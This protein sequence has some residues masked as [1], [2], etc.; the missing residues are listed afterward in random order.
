[1]HALKWHVLYFLVTT[2]PNP[3]QVET[4]TTA[5]SSCAI[6]Q[7]SPLLSVFGPFVSA[8][9]TETND[10]LLIIEK[11]PLRQ[12]SERNKAE[13]C[14]IDETINSNLTGMLMGLEI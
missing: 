9:L 6:Y 7:M 3:N 8:P 2:N 13:V 12:P 5:S 11:N 10:V 14:P 4:V 1:M